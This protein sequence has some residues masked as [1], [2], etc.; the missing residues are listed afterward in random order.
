MFGLADLY[1]C[2][3]IYTHDVCIYD[4]DTFDVCMVVCVCAHTCCGIY[5]YTHVQLFVLMI[6]ANRPRVLAWGS[7]GL[8]CLDWRLVIVHG[9]TFWPL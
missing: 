2:I 1:V 8:G 5:V 7:L 3:Y 4:N 9:S 6:K